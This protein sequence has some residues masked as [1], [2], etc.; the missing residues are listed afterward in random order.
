MDV[1]DIKAGRLYLGKK[2]VVRRVEG[3]YDEAWDTYVRFVV[4]IGPARCVN[5]KVVS[6]C[7]REVFARW[8]TRRVPKKELRDLR[9]AWAESPHNKPAIELSDIEVGKRFTN[10]VAVRKVYRIDH[11]RSDARVVESVSDIYYII[12]SGPQRGWRFDQRTV[13]GKP[14]THVFLCMAKSFRKWAT[15]GQVKG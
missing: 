1:S 15:E 6:G 2:G 3:M 10:G 9:K 13:D 4:V 7:K 12:E 8:A 14:G 5:Y 11:R